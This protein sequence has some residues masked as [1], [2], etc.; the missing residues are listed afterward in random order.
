MNIGAAIPICPM[1]SGKSEH[2][3]VCM[4]EKCAWYM[5]NSKLCSIYI[6]AHNNLL[7]IQK[8]QANNN[9]S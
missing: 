8:K 9:N 6:I 7:E 4:Q 3:M 1:L 2:D 5:K